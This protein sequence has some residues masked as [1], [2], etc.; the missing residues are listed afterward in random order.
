MEKCAALD[1]LNAGAKVEATRSVASALVGL[2]IPVS[3]ICLC[4]CQIER[5]SPG[6]CSINGCF[7]SPRLT[8]ARQVNTR[9]TLAI[10]DNMK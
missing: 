7:R 10:P 6:N 5:A 4:D 2:S 8:L 9:A 1:G 3:L